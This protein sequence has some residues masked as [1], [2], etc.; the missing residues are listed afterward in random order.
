MDPILPQLYHHQ[1]P[2]DNWKRFQGT[3][4]NRR[5]TRSAP[6]LIFDTVQ[7]VLV[8]SPTT[9]LCPATVTTDRYTKLT[10]ANRGPKFPAP[11]SYSDTPTTLL[12]TP[13]VHTYYSLVLG[14]QPGLLDH[15]HPLAAAI[16]GFEKVRFRHSRHSPEIR[17]TLLN[18]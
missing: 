16:I 9:A 15:L 10:T 11:P 7:E 4:S 13:A 6:H 18:S 8:S 12:S 5:P 3:S 14:T 2:G 17:F 1:A